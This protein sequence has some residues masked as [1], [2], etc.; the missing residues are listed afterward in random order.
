MVAQSELELE[1]KHTPSPQ[2][3]F[4]TQGAQCVE[5]SMATIRGLNVTINSVEKCGERITMRTE[6]YRAD[7]IYIEWTERWAYAAG[8]GK[9]ILYYTTGNESYV[10]GWDDIEI[11]LKGDP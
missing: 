10:K 8:R 2:G 6:I 4:E 7:S 5:W 3:V 1:V 9:L 11:V